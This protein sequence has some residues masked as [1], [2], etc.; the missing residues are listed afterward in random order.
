[1]AR[2][3]GGAFYINHLSFLRMAT[4]LPPGLLPF[5]PAR[6]PFV[7]MLTFGPFLRYTLKRGGDSL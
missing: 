1:M 2:P 5:V 4:V 3:I 6:I 7:L